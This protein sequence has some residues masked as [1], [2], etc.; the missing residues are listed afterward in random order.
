MDTGETLDG[1]ALWDEHKPQTGE[2]WVAVAE[3]FLAAGE[4]T[5]RSSPLFTAVVLAVQQLDAFR[6][7]LEDEIRFL[8]NSGNP[9][10]WQWGDRL[11]DLLDSSGGK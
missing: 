4:T 9:S 8:R 10:N 6:K 11:Q 3:R 1:M 5:E 7:G 2:D